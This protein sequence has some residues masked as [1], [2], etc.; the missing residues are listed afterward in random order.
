MPEWALHGMFAQGRIVAWEG[1]TSPLSA[2]CIFPSTPAFIQALA[3]DQGRRWHEIIHPADQTR[4]NNYFGELPRDGRPQSIEYRLVDRNGKDLW[5]RH[6]IVDVEPR[7]GKTTIRGFVAD[8]QAE[9]AS[10]LESIQAGEREKNRIAQDLHDD[11][12]QVLA[13]ISL[14]MR[15][16]EDRIMGRLPQEA[17]QFQELNRQLG[18]AMERTR[19]LAHGL[20][21]DAIQFKDIRDALEDLARQVHIRFGVEIRTQFPAFIPAHTSSQVVQI[22][23]IAQEAMS[24]SV[25]HGGA[26][27]ITLALAPSPGHER[28]QLTVQDNGRGL[29]QTQSA[30]AGMGWHSMQC[31]ADLLGADIHL[32]NDGPGGAVLR[33]IYPVFQ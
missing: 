19:S 7:D 29:P 15:A 17:K 9:K 20:F 28:M 4:V 27:E 31:R 22:Y 25:R 32:Y 21:T 14:L 5:I 3:L 6:S 33:L 24:N 26:T 10:Q 11:L 23:R 12:C 2:S 16:T 1:E 8:I 30:K 18:A 13:G